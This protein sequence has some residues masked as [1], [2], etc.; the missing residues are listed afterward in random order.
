MVIVFDK[1]LGESRDDGLAHAPQGVDATNDH[2]TNANIPHLRGPN[3]VESVDE[4]TIHGPTV[5]QS[6][7]GNKQAKAQHTTKEDERG[8]TDADDIAHREQRYREVH[9]CVE[10]SRNK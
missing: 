9:P 1:G 6:V 7:H 10:A 2:G 4:G 5:N 3:G 8:N